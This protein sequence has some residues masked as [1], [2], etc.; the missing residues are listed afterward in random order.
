MVTGCKRVFGATGLSILFALSGCAY[1]PCPEKEKLEEQL[2]Q[3]DQEIDRLTSSNKKK[4]MALASY[5]IRLNESA[6]DLS[7][8]EQR[9]KNAEERAKDAEQ[10]AYDA[11]MQAREAIA[12]KEAL[13]TSRPSPGADSSLLPPRAKP[14]ECYARVHVPPTYRTVTEQVLKRDS[15]ERVEIIPAKYE[16]VR[17]RVL[18]KEASERVEVVTAKNKWVEEKVLVK[19]SSSRIVEVPAKYDWVEEKVLV[20]PAHTVW[21]KGRGPIERVDNATGEIMCLVEIPA[22]YKTVKK[23]VMVSPPSTRVVEVPAKYET[24]KKQI[25]VKPPTT[26]RTEIPAVYKWVKVR[27]MVSPP[28]ERK[29]EVPA[30]Y[31]T[32]NRKEMVT[33]A[34]MEWRRILCETNLT[35]RLIA[36]IQRALRRAGHDPVYIDGMLGRRTK[37]A[38]RAYQ[39]EKG[40]AVGG[41]TYETIESLGLDLR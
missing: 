34:R 11:E 4:D 27:K 6:A 39:T 33:E 3:K 2:V 32:V 5:E 17:E 16:W 37:A 12:A 22:T 20:K 25:M 18:V 1:M 9:S 13:E 38:I 24:V 19:E 36:G 41:L 7:I 28:K 21:K 30:Q 8:A 10:R 15:S 23:R 29:I 26:K 31:Q 14:G 40:L 35:N